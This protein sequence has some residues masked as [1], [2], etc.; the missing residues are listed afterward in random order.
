MM[1]ASRVFC[2]AMVLAIASLSPTN[3][4]SVDETARPQENEASSPPVEVVERPM[5]ADVESYHDAIDYR[6]SGS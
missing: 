5:N 4:S 2:G 3:C 6:L 1:T